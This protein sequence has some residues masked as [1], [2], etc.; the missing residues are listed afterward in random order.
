MLPPLGQPGGTHSR[1]VG[2]V[3]MQKHIAALPQ[4]KRMDRQIRFGGTVAIQGRDE[5]TVAIVIPLYE[6][7]IAVWMTGDEVI[8]PAE[9][10]PHRLTGRWQRRPAKIENIATQDEGMGPSSG[11]MNRHFVPRRL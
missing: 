6:V 5:S 10:M 11:L 1:M 4:Q 2:R 3:P 8:H 9:G 7:K